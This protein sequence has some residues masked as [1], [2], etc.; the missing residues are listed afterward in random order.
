MIPISGVFSPVT[1]LPSPVSFDLFY[2]DGWTVTGGVG[3]KFTETISGAASITWDR[4]T[5][6]ISGY[7][8]DSVELCRW[9]GG[10]A[11]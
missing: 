10:C 2:R 3:H 5:S 7:Q 8:T 1:G 9:R 6:T 11:Q 4:G